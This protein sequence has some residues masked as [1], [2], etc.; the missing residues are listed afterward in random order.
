MSLQYLQFDYKVPFGTM[1]PGTVLV[2]EDDSGDEFFILRALKSMEVQAT[3]QVVR[4]GEEAT[5]YI[6][7]QGKYAGRTSDIC[8]KVIMPDLCIPKVAGL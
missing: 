5:D 3:V 8:P 6:F 1:C 2:V 7:R 4:D